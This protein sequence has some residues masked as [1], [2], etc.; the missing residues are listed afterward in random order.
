MSSTRKTI[1]VLGK[2]QPQGSSR[3]FV[4]NGKPVITSA[5]KNL[6]PWRTVVEWEARNQWQGQPPLKGAVLVWLE[7][8]LHRPKSVKREIPTVKPDLDKMI[9][10]VLDALTSAHVWDDDAQV[11]AIHASKRYADEEHPEGVVIQVDEL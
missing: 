11:W 2:P 10:S 1:R 6:K 4:V 7:F 8:R 3:A 5:N 9:R